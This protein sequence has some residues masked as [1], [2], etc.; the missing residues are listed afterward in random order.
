MIL[1][2]LYYD[3]FV[4]LHPKLKLEAIS[5]QAIAALEPANV[6]QDKCTLKQLKVRYMYDVSYSSFVEGNAS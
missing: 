3:S 2:Y 5:I 6:L 1:L 4:A